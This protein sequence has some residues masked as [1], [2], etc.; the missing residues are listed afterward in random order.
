MEM[1]PP[2]VPVQQEPI[3]DSLSQEMITE[4]IGTDEEIARVYGGGQKTHLEKHLHNME[5]ALSGIMMGCDKA[6]NPPYQQGIV[7]GYSDAFNS[8]H[9]FAK[10][11]AD[12]PVSE[13]VGII[14]DALKADLDWAW[15]YHC[16]IAMAFQDEGGDY[17]TANRAAARF[18]Q[19][20]A[21]V[22]TTKHPGY[23]E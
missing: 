2:D 9:A 16:N 6:G 20:W 10:Q 3:E 21:G 1:Q 15:S 22:D 8:T 13:A 18:M 7:K 12:T 4:R 11:L 14:V 19:L 5:V 23:F 17:K